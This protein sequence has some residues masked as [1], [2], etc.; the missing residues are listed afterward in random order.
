M[1]WEVEID[2]YTLPCD[3]LWELAAYHRELSSV[4]FGDLYGWDYN[5][6]RLI[7]NSCWICFCDFNPHLAALL[8]VGIHNGLPQGNDLELSA[9]EGLNGSE[10]NTSPCLRFETPGDICKD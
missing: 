9:S 8:K 1:N 3:S 10:T 2:I 6:E 5:L 7:L 4:F